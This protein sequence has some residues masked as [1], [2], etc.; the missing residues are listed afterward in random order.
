MPD[1]ALRHAIGKVHPW[2]TDARYNGLIVVTQTCD[3]VRRGGDSCKAKHVEV[4]P[5]RSL[6]AL[7]A[8]YASHITAKS[9]V[10]GV[11]LEHDKPPFEGFVKRILNQN[12]TGQGLFYLPR[13]LGFGI[14]DHSVVALR[15]SFALRTADHYEGLF[16]NRRGGLREAFESKLGWMMGNLYSRPATPD[17]NPTNGSSKEEKELIETLLLGGEDQT[18]AWVPK[19]HASKART[20]KIDLSGLDPP[21]AAARILSC[22]PTLPKDTALRSVERAVRRT[23]ADVDDETLSRIVAQLRNDSTFTGSLRK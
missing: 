4:A 6:H 18:I 13:D 12:E 7:L 21:A 22:T 17:W 19:A 9:V 2:L 1:S 15:V 10:P 11:Y 20:D 3:L 23:L 8:D 5:F 16:K 14:G